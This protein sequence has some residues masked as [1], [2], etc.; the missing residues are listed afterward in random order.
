MDLAAMG[1]VADAPTGRRSED[2]K[3]RGLSV[4]RRSNGHRD[5]RG[6]RIS[7]CRRRPYGPYGAY[8]PTSAEPVRRV[9]Q[10]V[11]PIF[12]AS[13]RISRRPLAHAHEL[14]VSL[15]AGERVPARIPEL[16]MIGQ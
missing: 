14:S 5:H 15:P 3:D 2:C 13:C 11:E 4:V 9:A 6:H 10:V 8:A 12:R 1:D 16:A 7:P